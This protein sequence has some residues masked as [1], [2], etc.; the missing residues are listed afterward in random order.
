[1]QLRG[2]ILPTTCNDEHR[3]AGVFLFG[4]SLPL[5]LFVCPFVQGTV[6]YVRQTD[7]FMLAVQLGQEI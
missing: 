3:L 2:S 5:A 4:A 1:M 6:E 7:I